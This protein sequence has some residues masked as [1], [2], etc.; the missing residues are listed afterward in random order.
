M[1]KSHIYV[2]IITEEDMY[3]KGSEVDM[4]RAEAEREC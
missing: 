3:L 2:T 1:Y 4:R